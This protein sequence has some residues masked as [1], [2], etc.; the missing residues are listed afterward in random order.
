VVGACI[1]AWCLDAHPHQPRSPNPAGQIQPPTLGKSNFSLYFIDSA[2]SKGCLVTK[3]E[4]RCA[5]EALEV[6]QESSLPCYSAVCSNHLIADPKFQNQSFQSAVLT[7]LYLKPREL[8]ACFKMLKCTAKFMQPL[9]L[10][11]QRSSGSL[12]P[13]PPFWQF[14][15]APRFHWTLLCCAKS[16]KYITVCGQVLRDS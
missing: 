9:G 1:W 11:C 16:P 4:C 10:Q 13:V 15:C 7:E 12:P 8:C 6:R 14:C 3:L 2:D 5:S